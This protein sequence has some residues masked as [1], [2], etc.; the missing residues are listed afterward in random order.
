MNATL[1]KKVEPTKS[2]NLYAL[3]EK[4]VMISKMLKTNLKKLKEARIEIHKAVLMSLALK[5][6]GDDIAN[7]IIVALAESFSDYE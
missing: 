7:Q 5:E 6:A 4:K 3:A 1:F 2:S